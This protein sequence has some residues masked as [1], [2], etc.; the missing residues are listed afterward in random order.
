MTGID[1]TG[2]T[3]LTLVSNDTDNW[4]DSI[5]TYYKSYNNFKIGNF[6][7]TQPFHYVDKAWMTK[8]KIQQMEIE[9]NK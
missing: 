5:P 1:L 8:Y 3:S 4:T 6:Q 9:V 2:F 7:I